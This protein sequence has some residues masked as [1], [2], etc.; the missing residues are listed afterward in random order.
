VRA[1]FSAYARGDYVTASEYLADDVVWE[2]GQ[3]LPARGPEAVR[4]LWERWDSD[5]S[6][7]ET[8]AE[9]WI[10]AGNSVVVAIRYRGCGRASGVTV[11]DLW[12]EVHRFRGGRCVSKVDYRTRDEALAAARGEA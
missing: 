3:E 5:W 7:L 8:T 6:E 2:V 12:W 11:D 9:E 1:S 4:E 10:D